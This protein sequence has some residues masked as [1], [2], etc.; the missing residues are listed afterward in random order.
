MSPRP[1]SLSPKAQVEDV[2]ARQHYS[3]FGIERMAW[4]EQSVC[5]LIR[6]IVLSPLLLFC[7]RMKS[8]SSLL[9]GWLDGQVVAGLSI[10]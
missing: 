5:F 9:V 6:R 4:W 10:L 7:H 1:E 8:R 2:A 3:G